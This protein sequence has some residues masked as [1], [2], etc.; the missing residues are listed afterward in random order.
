[1]KGIEH[2]PPPQSGLHLKDRPAW[3]AYV[4]GSYVAHA[5][6]LSTALLLQWLH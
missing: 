6:L 3:Q 4:L 2:V 5:V 1:M